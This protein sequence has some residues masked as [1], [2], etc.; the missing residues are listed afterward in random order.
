MINRFVAPFNVIEQYP[1]S[2]YRDIF[3]VFGV[4][5]TGQRALDVWAVDIYALYEQVYVMYMLWVDLICDEQNEY[6]NGTDVQGYNLY[7]MN[8]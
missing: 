2:I 1:C 3:G 4:F 5:D 8:M 6:E 7:K